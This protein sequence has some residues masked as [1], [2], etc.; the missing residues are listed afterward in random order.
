MKMRKTIT[1]NR[2]RKKKKNITGKYFIKVLRLS[3]KKVEMNKFF[4]TKNKGK[5]TKQYQKKKTWKLLEKYF[6]KKVLVKYGTG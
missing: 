3:I 1:G 2:R 4:Q 6:F 5:I